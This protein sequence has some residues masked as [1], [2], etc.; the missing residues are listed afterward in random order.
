MLY[1][2]IQG[3]IVHL[4]AAETVFLGGSG[5]GMAKYFDIHKLHQAQG[6]IDAAHVDFVSLSDKLDHETTIDLVSNL[7]PT[8]VTAIPALGHIATDGTPAQ[9][10]FFKPGI[11]IVP[12]HTPTFQTTL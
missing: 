11:D 3:G 2:Q 5:S 8:Q 1:K 9:Q 4:Q 7:L 12:S 10:I 6:E